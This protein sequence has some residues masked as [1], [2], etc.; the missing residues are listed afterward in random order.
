MPTYK[1]KGKGKDAEDEIVHVVAG[2]PAHRAVTAEGSGFELV[3][4]PKGDEAPDPQGSVG[5]ASSRA[6]DSEGTG[7]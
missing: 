3:S 7:S 1:R 4:N 6:A 5:R 2:S